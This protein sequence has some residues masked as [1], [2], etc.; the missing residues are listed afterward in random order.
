[1]LQRISG[2]DFARSISYGREKK[3]LICSGV[4]LL[5]YKLTIRGWLKK[6]KKIDLFDNFDFSMKDGVEIFA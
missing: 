6:D 1:L 3:K 4:T 5:I 2:C